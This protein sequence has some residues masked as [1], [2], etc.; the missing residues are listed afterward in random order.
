MELGQVIGGK[1]RLLR[2]LG[3]GGMGSVYEAH[4]EVLG[5]LVAIKV[6][7]G[8]QPCR[9]Q[10]PP[11]GPRSTIATDAPSSRAVRAAA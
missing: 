3:D 6:L 2:L 4:H 8:M 1:Y 9:M 5:S 11:S 10:S 7:D